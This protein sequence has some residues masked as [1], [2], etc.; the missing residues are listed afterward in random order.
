[1]AIAISDLKW[2]QPQRLTDN[3]D[4]GG[5]M[6]GTEVVDGQVN[7]L[8]SNI[9]RLA[10][11]TGEVSIRRM[12]GHVSTGN[13]DVYD[14]AHAA[15]MEAPADPRTSILLFRADAAEVRSAAQE[16][17]ERYLG[18][19]VNTGWYPYGDHYAGQT[20]LTLVSNTGGGVV[21]IVGETLVLRVTATGATEYVRV[22][23]VATELRNFTTFENGQERIFKRT[24]VT[25]TLY[26]PL[27]RD[28]I[29]EEA[30]YFP[31]GAIET[32]IYTTVVADAA[33]YY[34]ISTLTESAAPGDRVLRVNS[35]FSRVV[36][37]TESEIPIVDERAAGDLDQYIAAGEAY[38]L[39][40]SGTG[41][42]GL[43]EAWFDRSMQPG[44]VTVTL[45]AAG[46]TIWQLRDDGH[47]Q[48]TT[49]TGGAAP[50]GATLIYATCDYDAGRVQ[51]APSASIGSGSWSVDITATPAGLLAGATR[52]DTTA[53]TLANRGYTWIKTLSPR[54]AE[55]YLAVSY[56]SLNRWY[57]L[58]DN[59]RGVLTSGI[60][61]E[62]AGNYDAGTGTVILTTGYLPDVDTVILYQWG[63]AVDAQRIDGAEAEA[64]AIEI[65]GTLGYAVAP[66]AGNFVAEYIAGGLTKTVTMD[67]SGQLS[68]DG[69]GEVIYSTSQ[70]RIVPSHL[71]DYGSSLAITYEAI[72]PA[73]VTIPDATPTGPDGTVEI[74]LGGSVA[75]GTAVLSW[76]VFPPGDQPVWAERRDIRARDN[77]SGS[78][79]RDPYVDADGL[80]V[81][82][83][84]LGTINIAT[85][86]IELDTTVAVRGDV[87]NPSTQVWGGVLIEGSTLDEVAGITVAYIDTSG[88][89]T[90][91]ETPVVGAIRTTVLRD[92]WRRLVDSSLRLTLGGATIIA[93]GTALQRDVSTI[94]GIGTVCGT[95]AATGAIAITSWTGG[96]ANTLAVS[97]GVAQLGVSTIG[98]L[99]FRVPV[100]VVRPSSLTVRGSTPGGSESVATSDSGGNVNGGAI[101][102]TVDYSSGLV[103]VTFLSELL[104][105]TIRFSAVGVRYIPLDKE[106]L[107]LDPVRLPQD[108]RV[109]I[110]RPGDTAVIH[111]TESEALSAPLSAGQTVNLSRGPINKIWLT[112]ENGLTIPPALYTVDMAATPATITFADPLDLSAYQQPLVARHRVEL[113]RVVED[114]LIGGQIAFSEP[115]TAN[116][117]AD[118]SYISNVVRF[119]TLQ[120]RVA[121]LF[122]QRTWTNVWS[123][124]RIGDDSIASFNDVIAPIEVIN[125][126]AIT[127]RWS[128]IF[129]SSST[130]YVLGEFS[131]V[132]VTGSTAADC[133][134]I[135]PYTGEPYFVIPQEGWGT[136]WVSNNVLRFNTFGAYA[137]LWVIRCVQGGD[138]VVTQDQGRV[139]LRG[140]AD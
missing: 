117:P 90:E 121:S 103:R 8:L 130:F 89:T 21:P 5:R 100:P 3:A 134:P 56:R 126:N 133:A 67:A 97:A 18:Q 39:T 96:G 128:V 118:E 53:V 31:P 25:L 61:A 49:Y 2:K 66:G 91:V 114:V 109:P 104:A 137:P 48:L 80:I 38:T 42:T 129:D 30:T 124:S 44:S 135:N 20:V 72:T 64:T 132:V 26:L 19:G 12:F 52:S 107:K 63:T 85:G 78:L 105:S 17:I 46:I 123:D 36:P 68:G 131:G 82:D 35:V 9:T 62:G 75:S 140:D 45:K 122:T 99:A 83:E 74:D 101:I 69:T 57:T 77:G 41:A 81:D 54:P 14:G 102:G 95:V 125:R 93:R 27:L 47:G 113:M 119:D 23:D 55:G 139:E 29:G 110:F 60:A 59:G 111:H 28:Y 33:R 84:V 24:L 116:F 1:M 86:E 16:L 94:T 87:W 88:A 106:L 34:G 136:G 127:E 76:A 15:L 98:K 10:R 6:T 40:R 108:G 71:P 70:Y 22:R 120:A 58:R 73:S 92:S 37:A 4:G 138:A 79:V 50:V 11:A 65:T 51:V 43:Y 112:D 115:L 7:N 32:K 13:D